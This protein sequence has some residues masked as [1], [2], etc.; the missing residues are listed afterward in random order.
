MQ[1]I[2]FYS[3]QSDL[4]NSCNRG[5]IQHALENATKEIA[6]DNTIAVE[7]VIDRDTQGVP[8]SPDIASTIFAKIIA[9]DVFVA[10]ISITSRP[11]G[12]RQAPNP[13]VLIDSNLQY[14]TYHQ[15][16]LLNPNEI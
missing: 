11:T 5:F 12:G 6:S 14:N 7:P 2:I 13:N 16:K 10:D 15:Q 8:G 4:P 1:R 9:T 3:W